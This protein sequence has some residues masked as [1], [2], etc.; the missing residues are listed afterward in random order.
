MNLTMQ[1]DSSILSLALS[2]ILQSVSTL[3]SSGQ[4]TT[5]AKELDLCWVLCLL[6]TTLHGARTLIAPNQP[7]LSL[8]PGLCCSNGGW[9]HWCAHTEAW[10]GGSLERMRKRLGIQARLSTLKSKR[11]HLCGRN[12]EK[13]KKV[14]C[15]PQ[16]RARISFSGNCHT[17]LCDFEKLCFMSVKDGTY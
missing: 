10:R 13:E 9:L 1:R 2:L 15:V 6:W 8:L 16:V 11:L 12:P 7:C 5:K 4:N 14:D 17:L 3:A